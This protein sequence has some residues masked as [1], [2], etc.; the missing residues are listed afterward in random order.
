MGIRRVLAVLFIAAAP[1]LAFAQEDDEG[2]VTAVVPEPATLALL[3][4]AV[5]A[6]AISRGNKRQ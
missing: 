6:V 3:G 2:D 4:A 5:A 1:L